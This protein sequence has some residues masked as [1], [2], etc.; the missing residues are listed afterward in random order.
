MLHCQQVTSCVNVV[1]CCGPACSHRARKREQMSHM[2]VRVAELEAE[3]AA[4][5]RALAASNAEFTDAAVAKP[6]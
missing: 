3:N 2:S 6:L 1:E 5:R 4:L